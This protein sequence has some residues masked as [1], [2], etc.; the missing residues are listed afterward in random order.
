MALLFAATVASAAVDG[1]VVNKTTGKPQPGAT[2]MLMKIGAGGMQPVGSVKADAQGKFHFDENLDA[3]HL[4]QA[5][6]SGVTYNRMLQPGMPAGN[7]EIEVYNAAKKA[8][9]AKLAQHIVFLEPGNGQLAVNESY[10]FTNTGNVTLHDPDSGSFRLVLPD[11][12]DARVMATAP[13]GMPIQ[14]AAEKTSQKSVHKVDFPIKPGETRFDV[15]YTV[16]F[17]GT[18][19]FSGK[20][21]YKDAETRVAVPPGVNLKGDGLIALGQEP[22]T[23]APIFGIKAAEYKFDIEGTGSLQASQEAGGGD[24]G[25]QIVQILPRIYDNVLLVVIPALVALGL[26][27]ALLYRKGLA[28][29][30]AVPAGGKRRG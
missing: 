30:T 5:S 23:N 27:F 24:D 19:S 13:Q 16:P 20:L 21:L 29:E 1:T 18:G 12:V 22:S 14:R 8:P 28:R 2:V 15:S 9:D 4:A 26:G 11:G 25:P 10:F 3:P 7:L 17:S 6:F